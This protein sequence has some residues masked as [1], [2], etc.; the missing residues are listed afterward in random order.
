M[1]LLNNP[2]FR[3]TAVVGVVLT[4]ATWLLFGNV[5]GKTFQHVE[6]RQAN[7]YTVGN[8]EAIH[9]ALRQ[10]QAEYGSLP[11]AAQKNDQNLPVNSW[12]VHLLPWLGQPTR[13]FRYDLNEPWFSEQNRHFVSRMPARSPQFGPGIFE[14]WNEDYRPRQQTRFLAVTGPGTVWPDDGTVRL[15][16]I[17]HP[18]RTVLLLEVPDSQIHW[19]EPADLPLSDLHIAGPVHALFADGQVRL[20]NPDDSS[21]AEL[22]ALFLLEK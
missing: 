8:L 18:D 15:A 14:T 17:P 9:Y 6:D 16:D 11:P 22:R 4:A 10:Y 19:M 1:N 2:E 20:I 5:V 13:G 12:R 3:L 7:Q 21:R